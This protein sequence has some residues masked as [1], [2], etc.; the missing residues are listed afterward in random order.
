MAPGSAD[1][2]N[3]A[4]RDPAALAQPEAQ[5]HLLVRLGG[6]LY[7]LPGSNVREIMRWREPTPV[8]GAPPVLPGIINQRGA[9]LP[10]VNAHMLLGLSAPPTDRAT[11]YVLLQEG[12]V[13]LALLVDAVL[14]LMDLANFDQ[15]PLPAALDPQ[16]ARLLRA[17]T[18]W[19]GQPL[20]LLD[21]TA[22]IAALRA[23]AER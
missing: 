12:D 16:R 23:G 7:A 6:E 5:P 20:A 9:I 8:P 13:S 18:R 11:R 21:V 19:G 10:V 22:M 3:G 17:L 15:E 14:D 4:A 1:M 2:T